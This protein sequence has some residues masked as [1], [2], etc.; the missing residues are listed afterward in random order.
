MRLNKGFLVDFSAFLN[1]TNSV[2]LRVLIKL[3]MFKELSNV[4]AVSSA[5]FKEYNTTYAYN[6]IYA[7]LEKWAK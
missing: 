4:S 1:L 7:N 5:I 6:F 3:F 2:R